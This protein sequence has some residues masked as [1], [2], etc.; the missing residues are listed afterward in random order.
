MVQQRRNVIAEGVTSM[1]AGWLAGELAS[2]ISRS[3]IQPLLVAGLDVEQDEVVR[4]LL[5]IEG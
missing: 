2:Q 1:Q 5:A 4:Q 3:P